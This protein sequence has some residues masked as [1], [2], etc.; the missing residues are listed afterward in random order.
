MLTFLDEVLLR[1]F[2]PEFSSSPRMPHADL[3]KLLTDDAQRRLEHA[4]LAALEW[5]NAEVHGDVEITSERWVVTP[6]GLLYA[7][8][9][10]GA[11]S[12]RS[13]YYLATPPAMFEPLVDRTAA[14]HLDEGSAAAV[15]SRLN[16]DLAF[17][18]PLDAALRRTL[19]A[20]EV[21]HLDL[22]GH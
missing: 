12:H 19:D 7:A 21:L 13:L 11:G 4:R 6:R 3:E 15:D 16:R 2:G 5:A 10:S 8:G 18:W 9:L 20:H 1:Y 14:S 22:T 17:P